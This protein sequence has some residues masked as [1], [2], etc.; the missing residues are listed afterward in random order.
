M[1][2]PVLVA[3]GLPP[4]HTS[5]GQGEATTVFVGFHDTT[6]GMEDKEGLCQEPPVGLQTVLLRFAINQ[7]SEEPLWP[8]DPFT[9]LTDFRGWGGGC[10]RG[11]RESE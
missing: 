3:A 2:M 9:L 5:A 10:K 7:E 11:V 4:E 8:I 1:V 6:L